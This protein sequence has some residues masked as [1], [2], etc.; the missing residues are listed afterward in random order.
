M[1]ILALHGAGNTGPAFA[2]ELS[3]LIECTP[4]GEWVVPTARVSPTSEDKLYY[5]A[6]AGPLFKH[7]CWHLSSYSTPPVTT[8]VVLGF[9]MGGIATM[10]LLG[11]SNGAYNAV[12]CIAGCYSMMQLFGAGF[13]PVEPAGETKVLFI[14]GDADR[15]IPQSLS[16]DYAQYL[17][18]N[19]FT[20][21]RWII[22]GAGHDMTELGLTSHTEVVTRLAAWIS[23]AGKETA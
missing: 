3:S 4:Q 6:L 9:S 18:A 10:R 1:K 22:P 5:A 12:V 21:D 8:R 7:N 19:G 16:N 13:P 15:H 17:R 23:R 11:Q 20:V 14:H 2:A